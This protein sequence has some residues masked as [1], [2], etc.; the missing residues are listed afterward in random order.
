MVVISI[1]CIN[2]LAAAQ[3][4]PAFSLNVLPIY[5]TACLLIELVLPSLSAFKN[6]LK[7]VDLLSLKSSPL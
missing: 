4:D 6:S 7:T 2:N 5:G 3:L 1:N